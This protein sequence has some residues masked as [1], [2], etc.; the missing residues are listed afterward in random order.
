VGKVIK[1]APQ[2]AERYTVAMPSIGGS[3]PPIDLAAFAV[4]PEDADS[5]NLPDA[6]APGIDFEAQQAQAQAIIDDAQRAAQA[7]VDDAQARV[8]A[9]LADAESRALT[10]TEDARR[11]GHDDGYAL[12]MRE[13]DTATADTLEALR[14]LVESARTQRHQLLAAAEPELVR[15]AVGIAERVLHQQIAL[16]HGVVVEMARAAI[17]RIVDREKLTVRVNPADIERMRE[18]RDELL[19]LGDVKTMQVVEDQRVDRGGVILETEAGS[20]DAKI[21]TQLAEVRKILHIPAD[22]VV[23]PAA[24]DDDA[25]DDAAARAS[26]SE[27]DR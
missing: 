11:R 5:A 8:R 21:S 15:L 19:A 27:Q 6:A 2:S 23:G 20:I 12:G 13:A 18:H 1:G 14:G 16:D 9:V 24:P 17:A 25:D 22:A 26:E 7:L 3:P 4:V 10:L